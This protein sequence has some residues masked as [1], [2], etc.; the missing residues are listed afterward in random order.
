MF[1]STVIPTVGRST[2]NTAVKSVLDQ[3][4]IDDVNEIIVVNDSGKP[5]PYAE[6][7]DSDRVRVIDTNHNERSVA[8]NTGAAIAKGDYLHF[9]DDDDWIL[10]GSFSRFKRL[11]KMTKAGFI[12]GGSKLAESADKILY[13][14]NLKH[15]GNCFAQVMAGE[16]IPT[17][18]Y[19]IKR[20]IFFKAGA[21]IPS[22][23]V[24]EDFD[25]TRRAALETD[26][27][28]I[29]EPVL[30]ILRGSAWDTTTPIQKHQQMIRKLSLQARERILSH[31][32]A[33]RRSIHSA[34]T[35][36][37]RGHVLRTYVSSLIW[38]LKVRTYSLSLAR[39]VQIIALVVVSG[40]HLLKPEYWRGL[41][42]PHSSTM[43]NISQVQQRV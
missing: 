26:F 40:L 20:D 27:D 39:L 12:Y 38:N 42:K 41:V 1:V 7:M 9:L 10:P 2:L 14:I 33:F 43:V 16:W 34:N 3:K 13:E 31:P 28:F 25:F 5:L 32:D 11:T 22:M 15:K 36:Y 30:C 6:W 8:R 24:Y 17:G 23:V 35:T 37:W 4:N 21:F 19:L 29:E 18:S